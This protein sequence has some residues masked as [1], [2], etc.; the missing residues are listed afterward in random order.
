VVQEAGGAEARA[1][2]MAPASV[3]GIE[4]LE[5]ALQWARERMDSPDDKVGEALKIAFRRGG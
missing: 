3:E 1:A 4:N 2:A 5:T